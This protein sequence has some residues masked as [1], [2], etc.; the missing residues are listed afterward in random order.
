MAGKAL[1]AEY[2]EDVNGDLFGTDL[3][4]WI[5][6]S[7]IIDWTM[8]CQPIGDRKKPLSEN[9]MRRIMNGIKRYW[10]EAAE[11]IPCPLQRR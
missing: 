6:A 7:S 5:P 1:Y 8:P 11:L 4:P 3:K 10:G 2:P 9:T